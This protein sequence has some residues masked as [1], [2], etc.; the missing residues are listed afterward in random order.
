MANA[1]KKTAPAAATVAAAPVATVAA[2]VATTATAPAATTQTVPATGAWVQGQVPAG[3]Q[4]TALAAL[5]AANAYLLPMASSG[6]LHTMLATGVPSN[7]VAVNTLPGITK[8]AW[9][10]YNHGYM[11]GQTASYAACAAQTGNKKAKT[12]PAFT[13]AAPGGQ[14]YTANGAVWAAPAANAAAHVTAAYAKATAAAA[15]AMAS[16]ALPKA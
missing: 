9:A 11:L 5:C 12:N 15:L 8:G 3:Q 14:L 2:T 4:A 13:Y 10:K 1:A 7:A 6:V 16:G